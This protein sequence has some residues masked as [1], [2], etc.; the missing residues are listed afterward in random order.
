MLKFLKTIFFCCLSLGGF[1][2]SYNF[3]HFSVEEGLN[4]ST[5]LDITEDKFGNLWLAT[6]GGGIAKYDGH[7]FSYITIRDGLASNYIRSIISDSKG[8]IW[9]ATASGISKYDGDTII[10]YLHDPQEINSVRV[11]HEDS[12]QNIWFSYP[13]KEGIGRITGD[14]IIQ[15]NEKNGFVRDAVIDIKSDEDDNLWIITSI[16]GLFKWDGQK[17][18]KVIMNQDFKGFLLSMTIRADGKLL[19]GT[20]KGLLFYDPEKGEEINNLL[21]A[22]RNYFVRSVSVDDDEDI[23][24]ALSNGVIKLGNDQIMNF[25][26]REGFTSKSVNVIFKDR[27]GNLWFGTEGE[28]L[29][30]FTGELFF[31]L[32]KNHGLSGAPVTSV[33]ED[34]LGNIWMTSLGAG[35]DVYNGDSVYNYSYHPLPTSYFTSSCKD[36][37]GNL[38]FGSREGIIKYDKNG[39]TTYD[40]SDG[41]INNSVRCMAFDKKG[42]LWIGTVNGLSFFDGNRFYNITTSHGLADNLI[43]QLL[44]GA[45]GSMYIITRQG[46][47]KFKDGKLEVVTRDEELFEKRLNAVLFDNEGNLWIGYSGHGIYKIKANTKEITRITESNGLSSDFIYNMIWDDDKNLIIGTERGVDKIYL[48]E[49]KKPYFIKSYGRI[50]G[51]RGLKTSLNTAYKESDGSIWF[52]SEE[53]VY[54]YQ[55]HKESINEKAPITY[56]SSLKLFYNEIDWQ[57]HDYEVASWTNLPEGLRLEYDNNHIIFHYFGTSLTNPKEV[58]YQFRLKN[59]E[60]EWSPV[61]EKTEAAYTN[62]PPGKYTFMVRA[63][64][65]DGVWS[66]E[67]ASFEFY[68][69]SPFW[70]K[71]WFAVFV[72]AVFILSIKFFNDYRIRKQVNKLLMVERIRTEEQHNVRKRMARDFH[73]NMGNQ[74]ASI[75]V[76]VNLISMKLKDS[77]EE[78]KDLLGNIEKHSKS[79]FTG[80]K[81]FIWSIDPESDEIHELFTYIK[82]F[83]EELYLDTHIKFYSRILEEVPEQKNLP[84]GWSRQLVLIFKEAMTNALKHSDGDKVYFT[85]SQQNGIYQ[86]KLKD[87]GSATDDNKNSKGKGLKNMSVRANQIG[88]DLSISHENGYEVVLKFK[89]N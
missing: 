32:N 21:P 59:L 18:H 65:S 54:T 7:T 49:Q 68:I 50:E 43:W 13:G 62:L 45:D 30:K 77:S 71:W 72:A 63:A 25:S 88:A 1:S 15:Y 87:N 19:I 24:V 48:D 78:V 2:Q 41:L 20:N 10:N 69:D 86:I 60:E 70:Q 52:G 26:D 73:D 4:H 22:L 16:Y 76:Y 55:P 35:I 46:I 17:F 29:Y 66:Q 67:P 47:D 23:W 74:L 81:D 39:F 12:N 82:D 79:L 31:N 56:I 36:P 5:I 42:F 8:N 34:D 37:A 85:M 75:T 9:S 3:L 61:T 28:G 27:E 40:R 33:I 14:S 83:G 84:I 53:G 51:F 6:Q 38:W 44:P 57:Q 11:V 80:T 89:L 58:K 64:N